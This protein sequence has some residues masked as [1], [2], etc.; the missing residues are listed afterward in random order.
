MR[1]S[2]TD[3]VRF[4]PMALCLLALV[5]PEAG[6]QEEPAADAE[7]F[8]R[9]CEAMEVN[10]RA[11]LIFCKATPEGLEAVSTFLVCYPASSHRAEALYLR[12]IGNWNLYH[13]AEAAPA[14]EAYLAEAP[15]GPLASLARTRFVQALTRADRGE[16]ALAALDRFDEEGTP[17]PGDQGAECRAGALAL[18]GRAEEA[19]DFLEKHIA[20]SGGGRG[21]PRG[22]RGR[23]AGDLAK[24]RMIGSPLPAFE[25][26]RYGTDEKID[27]AS[28]RGR[29]VL[30]D[31][32]ATWCRP[33]VAKL[34]N[35]ERT[36][37]TH[38]ERGFDV[39]GVSLD[40]QTEP[41]DRFLEARQIVWP[42]YADGKGWKNDLAVHFEV[43]R[44]PFNL[45]VDRDGIVRA[46]GVP[47]AA[48]ERWVR[49]LIGAEEEGG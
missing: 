12:A 23:L 41:L 11:H 44:V 22:G 49:D 24:L 5:L 37:R 20:S 17:V 10:R 46:V 28:L 19:V 40:H 26:T 6:A 25:V 35:I 43:S 18:L 16:D 14:Y 1:R 48:I 38:H 29:V 27:P 34:P 13:Y 33:C 2:G 45:L 30:V 39:F 21:D 3:P 42:Q 31:F 7:A 32:W 8:A 4:A 15:D 36:Y 9:L 47:G